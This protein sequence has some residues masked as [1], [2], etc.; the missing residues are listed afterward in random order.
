MILEQDHSEQSYLNSN[1]DLFADK[2]EKYNLALLN[3]VNESSISDTRK[4]KS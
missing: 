4:T 3:K 2:E 1:Q